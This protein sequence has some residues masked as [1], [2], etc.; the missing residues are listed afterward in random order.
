MVFN[1]LSSLFLASAWCSLV[2]AVALVGCTTTEE[3]EPVPAYHHDYIKVLAVP[4]DTD[5]VLMM[6]GTSLSYS[7]NL[8]TTTVHIDTAPSEDELLRLEIQVLGM[9]YDRNRLAV[10]DYRWNGDTLQV[11]CGYHQP[12][13]WEPGAGSEKTSYPEPWFMPGRVDVKLPAGVGVRYLGRWFE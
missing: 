13:S 2:L 5:T 9:T 12:R 6:V 11:W 7:G 4:V 3:P 1:R 10:L 8:D